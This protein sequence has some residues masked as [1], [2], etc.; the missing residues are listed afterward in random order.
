MPSGWL[1]LCAID[2]IIDLRLFR[3]QIVLQTKHN[4]SILYIYKLWPA[5]YPLETE[6]LDAC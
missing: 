1:N 5:N 2:A 6:S 3:A 4:A